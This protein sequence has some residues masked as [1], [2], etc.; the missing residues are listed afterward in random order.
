[1]PPDDAREAAAR[2][3][4][5]MKAS[6]LRL[7]RSAVAVGREWGPDLARLRAPGLLLWG[8]ADPYAG[9]EWGERLAKA[10]GARLVVLPGCSHWWSLERPAEVAAEITAFWSGLPR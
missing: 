9:P 5:T 6:I 7:Y 8:A 2:L 10:T 1:M 4:E 3:D